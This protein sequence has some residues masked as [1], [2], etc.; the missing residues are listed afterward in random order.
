[1]AF[2]E[3]RTKEDLRRRAAAYAAWA[4]VSCGLLGRSP[5]YLNTMLTHYAGLSHALE[6]TAPK[7]GQRLKELYLHA[8]RKDLHATHTFT[9][10]FAN[11]G[12]DGTKNT[13]VMRVIRE[14]S[15]GLVISGARGLATGAPFADFDFNLELPRSFQPGAGTYSLTFTVPINAR[16]LSWL[17][18]DVDDRQAS[19]FDSPLS[20]RADE[21]DCVAVFDEVTLR[22]DDIIVYVKDLELM[23]K[24]V[25][26]IEPYGTPLLA[27]QVLIRQAAKT[28]FILGL[29][30]LI[31]ESSQVNQ[32]V[33]V[34]ERL[35]DIV[36]CRDLLE[37]A[38]VA[39]VENAV[40][41]PVTGFFLPDMRAASAGVRLFGEYYPRMLNHL[42]MM[43]AGRFTS[44]PQEH[45]LEVLGTAIEDY[46]SSASNT[47]RE[48]VSLYRLA[49]ELAGSTFGARQDLYERFHYGDYTRLK[50][51]HYMM[52]DKSEAIAMVRRL[53][54][55][56]PTEQRPFPLPAKF[57]GASTS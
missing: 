15:E 29:A 48:Q 13:G 37:S 16:G 1:M 42:L 38:A 6:P 51:G 23:Q 55:T 22:W 47:A 21:V 9:Q 28:R 44:T 7:V 4:E 36:L 17:C 46:F 39:A 30:H 33:G 45:T 54:T 19:S 34:Q 8:R 10:P 32:F 14:T 18:R 43:G 5:D 49:W 27:H 2:L 57:G 25:R 53:L 24:L 26:A 50:G 31:A 41:D 35:G 40:Q 52:T 12:Q 20:A 11:R 3:P 56:P